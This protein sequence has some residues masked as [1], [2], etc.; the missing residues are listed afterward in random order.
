M[1]QVYYGLNL[2]QNLDSAVVNTSTNSTDVEVR[3]NTSNVA[4]RNDLI[5][6]LRNLLEFIDV[7]NYPYA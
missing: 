3:V 2:G 6:A 1:A 4:Y 5:I 7:Q